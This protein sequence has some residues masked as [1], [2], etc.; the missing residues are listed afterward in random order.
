MNISCRRREPGGGNFALH[1]DHTY[2]S[3]VASG[4][5]DKPLWRKLSPNAGEIDLVARAA[6]RA[7]A[8]ALTISNTCSAQ[9]TPRR[10]KPDGTA[11]AGF[12]TG[13]QAHHPAHGAPVLEGGA[14][15]ESSAAAASVKVEDVV[16][17]MLAARAL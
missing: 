16:E 12:G 11:T 2:G 5:A 7:G 13:H 14:D 3:F 17:Y 9:I 10:S 15:P 1:E 8:D 4:G 6:E